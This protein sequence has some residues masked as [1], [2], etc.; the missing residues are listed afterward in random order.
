[1]PTMTMARIMNEQQERVTKG[2]RAVD[3]DHGYIHEG[4]LFEATT[5]F[6][7][8]A[9]ASRRIAIITPANFYLHYRLENVTSS[10]DKVAIAFHEG[11]TLN[12]VPGGTALTPMNHSR[13]AGIN[14]ATVVLEAPTVTADGTR[15]TRAYI[16]GGTGV[17]GARTGSDLSSTHEWVLIP[18]T[19]YL[20]IVTN[21]SSAANEINMN[22]C[23]YEETDA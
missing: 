9:A 22:I 19:T 21:N 13:V 3:T 12:A 1:M 15:L 4:I 20:I 17:G 18:S 8:N 14:S 6:S 16:G 23:W 5:N 2:I 10:G 7:L 11:A